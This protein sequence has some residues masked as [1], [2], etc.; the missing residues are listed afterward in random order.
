MPRPKKEKRTSGSRAMTAAGM[1]QGT[2]WLTKKQL[3]VVKEAAEIQ[4]RSA[5]NLVQFLIV[6]G[7]EKI[8]NEH[9]KATQA[10]EPTPQDI[11][12]GAA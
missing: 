12:N 4:G 7:T 1:K 6:A 8:V 5:M 10:A 11:S 3:D 2:Y 9:K